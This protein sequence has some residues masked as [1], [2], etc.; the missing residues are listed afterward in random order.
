MP[1][2][3]H[4][5]DVVND[6]GVGG[7]WHWCWW[8]VD[9]EGSVQLS[10]TIWDVLMYIIHSPWTIPFN[11]LTWWNWQTVSDSIELV[12]LMRNIFEIGRCITRNFENTVSFPTKYPSS[13]LRFWVDAWQIVRLVQ[14]EIRHH[15]VK[16]EPNLASRSHGH[17][18]VV[19]CWPNGPENLVMSLSPGYLIKSP[20]DQRVD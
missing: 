19:G 8:C 17:S 16:S 12:R 7:Q 4:Y 10:R 2:N 20:L 13:G 5:R 18:T 11:P 1:G 9:G 6:G 3:I 15:A 14:T